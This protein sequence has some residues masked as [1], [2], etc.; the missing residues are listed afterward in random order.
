MSGLA[1]YQRPGFRLAATAVLALALVAGMVA[2]QTP[3]SSARHTGPRDPAEVVATLH[4]GGRSY[5]AALRDLLKAARAAP[6]DLVAAKAASRA[7]INQGRAAGDGRLVGASLGLLRPFM[8]S[9]D[10]EVLTLAATARQYQHDFP[11]ALTLLDQAIALDPRDA[12][13]LLIRATIH[14]VRGEFA[15]AKTDCR[16]IAGLPRPDLGYLCAATAE[17][18]TAKAPAIAKKLAVLSGQPQIFDPALRPYALSLIGEIAAL[19]G[20]ADVAGAQFT[21]LLTL[22][23]GDIRVRLMLADLWLQAA[24][25][26]EVLTLLAPAPD[27]DGVLI[28]RYLAASALKQADVADTAKAELEKRFRLNLDLGLTAH[29]RE[30]AQYFLYVAPNPALALARAEINWGLQHEIDD[31]R[32][33]INAAVAAGKP[34]AAAPALHWMAETAIVVPT[35]IIPDAVREAAQ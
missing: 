33:L 17:T 16:R 35:L 18:L 25:P 31:L 11:G 19:Q 6:D 10:A 13:S 8:A 14:I 5:P 26:A 32:L 22:D 7:L 21:E 24:K 12:N 20:Q 27:V 3:T 30:E 28:R 2:L 9:Q 1:L 4:T 15:A 29:A 23:P 34:A